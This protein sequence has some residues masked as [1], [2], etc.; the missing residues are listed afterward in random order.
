MAKEKRPAIVVVFRRSDGDWGWKT[1]AAN[2]RIVSAAGEGFK[3]RAYA[4]RSAEKHNQDLTVQIV[5][6]DEKHKGVPTEIPVK[7]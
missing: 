3:S 5:I 2:G 7:A 4:I 6:A 1:V